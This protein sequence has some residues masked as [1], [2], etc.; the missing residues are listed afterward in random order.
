MPASALGELD[1]LVIRG[2]A[3][4]EAARRLAA[5]FRTVPTRLAG[6]A[7]VL[8]AAAALGGWVLTADRAFA[9]KLRRRGIGTVMPRDRSRLHLVRGDRP[10]PLPRD[11][12]SRGTG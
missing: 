6:D 3:H 7:A 5:R 8:E 9:E 2:V 10:T 12:S 11:P 1:R 4:A